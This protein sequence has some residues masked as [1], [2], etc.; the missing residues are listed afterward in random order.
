MPNPV[1]TTKPETSSSPAKI[2]FAKPT[3]RDFVRVASFGDHI[4]GE[5]SIE[6]GW[7]GD[8]QLSKREL[9][10]VQSDIR[11]AL[12]GVEAPYYLPENTQEL[13][14]LLSAT[15][16]LLNNFGT[17]DADGNGTIQLPRVVGA[18]PSEPSISNYTVVL[19]PATDEFSSFVTGFLTQ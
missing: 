14:Q 16:V 5:R 18:N 11:N 4:H 8:F 12:T 19:D 17:I 10:K 6:N 7:A 13:R 1:G 2:P 9:T 15:N 3:T